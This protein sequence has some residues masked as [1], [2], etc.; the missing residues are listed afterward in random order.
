MCELFLTAHTLVVLWTTLTFESIQDLESLAKERHLETDVL[1]TLNTIVAEELHKCDGTGPCP[2][3]TSDAR[4]QR[5]FGSHGPWWMRIYH[6][7]AQ[8][9]SSSGSEASLQA[10]LDKTGAR[11]VV[12]GHT[13]QV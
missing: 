7:W 9:C 2:S 12:V 5:L 1:S 4:I 10:I 13:I 3:R 8:R 6:K 11:Q